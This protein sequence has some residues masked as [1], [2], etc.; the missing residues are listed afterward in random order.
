MAGSDQS[1]QNTIGYTMRPQDLQF[2]KDRTVKGRGISFSLPRTERLQAA[3]G[4]PQ[5]V[6]KVISYARGLGV[7]RSIDYIDRNGKLELENEW[8]ERIKGR[9][10]VKQLIKVWS[11]NFDNRSN[12][13][14]SVHIAFSMPRGSNPEALRNAV[15]M[16][17]ESKFRGH[18]WVFAIHDDRPHPHAHAVIKMRT[19]DGGKKLRL[20]KP[21]LTELRQSFAQAA[22]E[23]GVDLAASSRAARGVGVKGVPFAIYHMRKRGVMPNMDKQAKQEIIRD[24]RTRNFKEAPWEKAMSDRNE[25][26]RGAYQEAAKSYRA[27]AEKTTDPQSKKTLNNAAA[28]LELYARLMPKP[29]T[30]RRKLLEEA[31]SLGSR[32][33]TR[34][35]ER[36]G[37]FER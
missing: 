19:I 17:L 20:N 30:R 12:S 28:I 33:R 22:R 1:L 2:S 25:R 18:E 10:E 14:D 34:P 8:G 13:R 4:R 35:Q 31:V 36:E 7:R 9:E 27:D 24:L 29:K 21:Q 32:D 37:G 23:Y 26:E 3:R 15:R 16:T 5:A 6:V 11:R